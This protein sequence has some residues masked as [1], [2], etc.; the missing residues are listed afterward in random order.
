[1]SKRVKHNTQASLFIG[2]IAPIVVG[3]IAV[4]IIGNQITTQT[5][6][7]AITGDTFT[8]VND[9]CVRVTDHCFL[10]GTGS[11][12]NASNGVT[13]GG[14]FSECGADQDLYGFN[15]DNNAGGG[16][17]AP[18]SGGSYN[19]SYTQIDCAYISGSLS[20]MIVNYIPILAVIVLF[21][22]LA[23]AGGLTRG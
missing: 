21:V 10:E 14:N 7:L 5:S 22:G 19:A 9:T 12:I 13:F 6:T 4:V 2:L 17:K 15:L 18:L 1:M 16:A 11:V 3:I 8:G 20:R 23:V